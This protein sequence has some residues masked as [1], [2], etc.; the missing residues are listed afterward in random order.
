MQKGQHN[1]LILL[2]LFLYQF[3]CI[4]EKETYYVGISITNYIYMEW[5]PITPDVF[6]Q[7]YPILSHFLPHYSLFQPSF[8]IESDSEVLCVCMCAHVRDQQRPHHLTEVASETLPVVLCPS[9]FFCLCPHYH[10]FK[11]TSLRLRGFSLKVSAFLFISF[12]LFQY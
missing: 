8:N 11:H 3:Y 5:F 9:C 2:A 4:G 7:V 6:C 10:L 1:F 12:F